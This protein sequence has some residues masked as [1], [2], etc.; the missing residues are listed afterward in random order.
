M[1]LEYLQSLVFLFETNSFSET[2]KIEHMTQSAMSRRISAIEK[3][4][5]ITLIFRDTKDVQFTEAGKEFYLQSKKIL[6]QYSYAIDI[7]HNIARGFKKKLNVGIGFYEHYLLN[8]FLQ[9]FLKKNI[10]CNVSVYQYSYKQLLSELLNNHLDII[11]TS[12]QFLTSET[13]PY[14]TKVLINDKNWCLLLNKFHP[15]AVHKSIQISQLKEQVFVSMYGFNVDYVRS[16][17]ENTFHVPIS[18]I[19][20]VVYANSCDAK[21]AL[22]NANAGISLIPSFITPC[23]Y[24]NVIMRPFNPPYR[25]RKFYALCLKRKYNGNIKN[26]IDMAHLSLINQKFTWPD[27]E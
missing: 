7:S 3:E 10:D 26:F 12:D 11:L 19:S 20:N 9:D 23:Q 6:K 25:H 24:N 2:A 27:V 14:Y 5:G 16:M 17:Y 1:N 21:L 15:L 13:D 22:I 18:A 4:T 8:Y